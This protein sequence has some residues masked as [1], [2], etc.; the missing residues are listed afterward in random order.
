MIIV[1]QRKVL[2]K[3][4]LSWPASGQ[5]GPSSGGEQVK[6]TKVWE[7]KHLTGYKCLK[8]AETGTTVYHKGSVIPATKSQLLTRNFKVP[9][10]VRLAW[11]SIR[12]ASPYLVLAWPGCIS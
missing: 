10:G 1:G 12:S 7:H 6:G 9:L 11:S 5:S 3:I 8:H 2:L 4:L